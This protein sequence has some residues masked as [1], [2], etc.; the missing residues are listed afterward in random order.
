MF[1]E[2]QLGTGQ[3]ARRF[4]VVCTA[5][6]WS[7]CAELIATRLRDHHHAGHLPYEERFVFLKGRFDF[8][9]PFLQ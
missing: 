1:S 8:F 2:Y 3:K 7:V 5:L 6:Q 4:H 9:P